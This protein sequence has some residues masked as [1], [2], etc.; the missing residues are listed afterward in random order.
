[1]YSIDDVY[2]IRGVQCE[3][4]ARDIAFLPLWILS[5]CDVVACRQVWTKLLLV[6]SGK[7]D[8]EI[9]N[10]SGETGKLAEAKIFLPG[11]LLTY[12][13]FLWGLIRVQTTIK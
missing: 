3:C 11:Q 8:V 4:F 13:M 10:Y 9:G 2:R 12:L 6:M 5:L 7:N 1:M